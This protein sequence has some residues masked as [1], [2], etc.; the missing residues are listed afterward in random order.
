MSLLLNQNRFINYILLDVFCSHLLWVSIIDDFID[1]LINQHEI[2]PN[3]LFIQNSTEVSKYFH[4]SI[5]NVHHIWRRDI[6]FCCCYKK[7]SKFF[8]VKVIDPIDILDKFKIYISYKTWRRI[9]L[10]KLY[11]SEEYLTCL[12][13]QI[14]SDY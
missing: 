8:C 10:P 11:F 5:Q 7:D 1:N 14:E 13:S 6:V 4:H 2:L 9:A 3:T 12:S